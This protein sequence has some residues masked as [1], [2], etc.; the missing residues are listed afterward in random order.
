VIPLGVCLVASALQARGFPV[1]VLDLCFSA[2]PQAEIAQAVRESRPQLIGL[3]IRNLDNG[4]FLRPRSY[5][6]QAAEAV[7]ACR[8]SGPRGGRSG[9]ARGAASSVPLVIGGSAVSVAPAQMLERLEA[10]YAVIGDG[11]RA[12]PA[13]VERLAAGEPA[14]G[15]PGVCAR[16]DSSPPAPAH[17]GDLDSLGPQRAGHWIDLDRYAARGSL[18]PV[19]SKR[20][21]GFE[22]LYCTYPSIEGRTY[23]LRSPQAVV[24]EMQEAWARWAITGFEFVDSVFNH[25][26]EHA[27]LLCESIAREGPRAPLQ[28][29]ALNP[30]CASEELIGLMKQAGFQAVVCSAESGSQRMLDSLRKGFDVADVARAAAAARKAGLSVLWSFVFGGPGECEATV[31]ETLEFIEKGLGPRD[32]LLCAVGLRVYPGTELERVARQ[33]PEGGLRPEADLL[34]PTFYFSPEIAPERVLELLDGSARRS[35]MLHL[36]ELQRPLISWALRVKAALRVP[37]PPWR[38]VPLYNWMA[39]RTGGRGRPSALGKSG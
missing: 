17:V 21:C 39:H 8:P 12:M 24:A 5:L 27:L 6:G 7:R 32:R 1:R 28:T 14:S 31:R 2:N 26:L 20:G 29:S 35:Q 15:I 9:P 37:G 25:P 34:E 10:D 3:S 36:G 22:C 4:D 38:G 13:L 11:E 18:M 19:Q 33:D 30:R 23:R 16:G